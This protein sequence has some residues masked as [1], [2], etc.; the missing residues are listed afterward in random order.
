MSD[1]RSKTTV[2]LGRVALRK[3]GRLWVA[4]YALPDT[5]DDAIFIASIRMSAVANHS[6]R[7]RIFIDLV[8]DYVKDILEETPGVKVEMWGEIEAPTHEKT[9]NA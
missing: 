7:K 9:G 5:M 3:E 4:Y 1:E 2:P 6:E 8:Q